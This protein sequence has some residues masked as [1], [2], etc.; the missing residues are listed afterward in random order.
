MLNTI[1]IPIDLRQSKRYLKMIDGTQL[2]NSVKQDFCHKSITF[3][4]KPKRIR[5]IWSYMSA[6]AGETSSSA[7]KENI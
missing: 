5:Y 2:N 6:M 4:L 3:P 7:R 1:K